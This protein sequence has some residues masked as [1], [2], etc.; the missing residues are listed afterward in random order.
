MTFREV[1]DK[2]R[3]EW[4]TLQNR[5]YITISTATCGRA[6][7]ALDIADLINKELARRSMEIPVIETGCM[8]LCYAEP[9]VTISKLESLRIVYHNITPELVP[10]L[11]D[12]YILGDD[13]CL[14]LALGT[15]ETEGENGPYIPEL[16]RF[17]HELRL[18]LRRCGYI[19]PKNIYHY[20][21]NGGY[22]GLDKALRM[23]PE[24]IIGKVKGSGLRGRGGAGFPAGS[25]WE[26]CRTAKDTPKYVIC[27]GDEGDPGA[28]MDRVILESDPQQVIEGMIIAGYAIGAREGY[29]YVRAE[30]PLAV[31]R[32]QVALRQAKELGFLGDDIMG[33][34]FGF[35]I[36]IAK[37]A[38]AFVSGEATAL[39][40]AMEG[41][42]SE[43]RP[44]PPRLAEAGLWAKPTLL[45]NV[46]TFSYVPLIIEWGADWFSGIG[47]KRSKGTAVFALAG[48]VNNPGLTEVPMG[49]TLREIVYDIAGGMQN[50]KRF[51]GVQI[52]GPSGGCLPESLLDTPVDF[53]SLREAGSMMG[54]G[55][56]IFMDEGDCAVD[57]AEFFLDF[58]TRESCGKCTMCR[59][60][61]LHLLHI[62]EDITKGR[63]KMEDIDLLLALAEDVKGGS[64]C[65]LGSTAPNPILT[66][67]RYFRDEYE[68][69]IGE[70]RC[71]ALVC[72]ELIAYYIL[73][74]KCDRGCEHC[75]LVCPTEAIKGGKGEVKVIDQN[76]CSKCSSCLQV[77]PPEYNAVVKLSPI[78]ELPP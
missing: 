69:H 19:D 70:K 78:S 24:E 27:N 71:P 30:Y 40:S 2:A 36:E 55:G 31:E 58:V 59:L 61:T 65:G 16:S 68:A 1:E 33:S 32:T 12:G 45:N 3:S 74:E 50:G 62:L 8:G 43:P 17:E 15:L 35:H 23:S 42:R 26:L 56:M 21:A 72:K 64:L 44:R 28:F 6:A 37:G 18:I 73:P 57:T 39:V 20:I 76:K 11:I 7:G 54:S 10:R 48:K 29:I 66:T 13:P 5:I 25:K 47:T 14:E 53:D 38:G 52:G 4:E 9:L 67:L 46:K 60:G 34:G 41:R 77:C 22:R 75:V 63:G 51:K 49:T